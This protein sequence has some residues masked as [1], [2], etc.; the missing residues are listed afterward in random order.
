MFETP[1]LDLA[2]WSWAIIGLAWSFVPVL[3]SLFG[4]GSVRCVA[5][6]DSFAAFDLD[7]DG[8]SRFEQ[9]QAIGFQPVGT[10]TES[11]WFLMAIH[12]WKR[13]RIRYLAT[14]NR[15]C[16]ASLYRVI[17]NEPTRICLTT[18]TSGGGMVRTAMPG[19]GL[20][21]DEETYMRAEIATC[22]VKE[23]VAFHNENVALF[24]QRRQVSVER[25]TLEGYA[26]ANERQLRQQLR[27]ECAKLLAIP[28]VVWGGPWLALI[29]GMHYWENYELTERLFA[30]SFGLAS[31]AYFIFIKVMIPL[32]MA[33]SIRHRAQTADSDSQPAAGN[34][35]EG[36]DDRSLFAS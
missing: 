29:L 31:T 34:S 33:V 36:Q 35:E 20:S 2:L 32:L 4:I 5:D 6:E 22:T 14:A 11:V 25:D 3:F 8:Q 16:F 7:E 28:I 13:A 10:I 18:M 26:S 24:T 9:L 15:K 27:T 17:A 12:W 23:L 21:V 19:A 30:I 1:I